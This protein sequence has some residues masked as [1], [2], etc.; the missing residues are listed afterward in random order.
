MRVKAKRHLRGT[1]AIFPRCLVFSFTIIRRCMH[2]LYPIN[3]MCASSE[4]PQ[5]KTY[6]K[7]PATPFIP[8]RLLT[9]SSSKSPRFRPVADPLVH[10]LRFWSEMTVC[11]FILLMR[12][13]HAPGA[14]QGGHRGQ[15][16]GTC[17]TSVN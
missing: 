5:H 12:P 9:S 11:R 7:L 6:Y 15:A 16:I 8:K 1:Q 13:R 17:G 2:S 10:F 3:K 4:N 14:G